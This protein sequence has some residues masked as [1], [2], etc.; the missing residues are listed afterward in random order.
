TIAIDFFENWQDGRVFFEEPTIN[1]RID[2]SFGIPTRSVVN[3]FEV[4]SATGETIA[5]TSPVLEEGIDFNFPTLNEIGETKTTL[6]S[7][8]NENSNIARVLGSA[9]IAVIYDVDAATNPDAE[10]MVSGFVTDSSKFSVNV[11]VD[12]P[13]YGNADGFIVTDTF[14][15]DFG[16]IDEVVTAEFKVVTENDLGLDVEL[17]AYFVDNAGNILDSLFKEKTLIVQGAPVDNEGVSTD[18]TSTTEFINFS[19]DQFAR[20]LN[21]TQLLVRSN[22]STIDNG[23]TSV[24]VFATDVVDLRI[25]L[26]VG[27]K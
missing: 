10:T 13:L 4:M 5:L 7:F 15:L 27:T 6:F 26:K 11:E 22:F 25:G 12:L 19:A 1:I 23:T 17:Q 8:T 9:P 21:S 20:V 2:N 16:D 14:A 24:K 3:A 18:R